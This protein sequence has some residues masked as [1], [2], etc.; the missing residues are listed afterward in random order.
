MKTLGGAVSYLVLCTMVVLEYCPVK[1][2]DWDFGLGIWIAIIA[3]AV[4][5][6]QGFIALVKASQEQ[7]K[8]D[9]KNGGKPTKPTGSGAPA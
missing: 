1:G 6:S 5:N 9:N 3:V 2:Y 7:E 8:Q 4:L